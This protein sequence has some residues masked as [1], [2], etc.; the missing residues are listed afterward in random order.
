MRPHVRG[1]LQLIPELEKMSQ[2]SAT[3]HPREPDDTPQFCV[4]LP[5]SARV[6]GA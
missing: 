3:T 1:K 5:P 4:N 6:I 2:F